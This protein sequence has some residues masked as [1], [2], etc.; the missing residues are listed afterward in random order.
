MS[1]Q[2]ESEDDPAVPV[3]CEACETTT[4]VPLSEAAE[5][6]QQHNERLHDGEERAQIDPA[7]AEKIQDLV[8]RDMGLLE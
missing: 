1:D 7:I 6:I 2:D 8:A 4:E 5:T 3:V